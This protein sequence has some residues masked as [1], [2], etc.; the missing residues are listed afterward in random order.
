MKIL[1]VNNL[2][3]PYQR[4][5]AEEV[6][7]IMKTEFESAGHSVAIIS[8]AP[9]GRRDFQKESRMQNVY[10]LPSLFFYLCF[11]PLPLRFLWHLGNF[12]PIH[13]LQIKKIISRFQPDLVVTHN[14]VGIGFW[15]PL[16]LRIKKIR[17][18]HYLHDIQLLHPSGLL[19]YRQERKI[20]SFFSRCYQWL[21]RRFFGSPHKVISPSDWLINLHRQ[22][23]FFP[24]SERIVLP[25]NLNLSFRIRQRFSPAEAFHFIYIG[26]LEKHKGIIELLE[27]FKKLASLP[28][29]S[30]PVFLHLVGR[31]TY[32]EKIKSHPQIITYGFLPSHKVV[33]LLGRADCLIVPSLCYENYPTIIQKALAVGCPVIA[34]SLGGNIELL[35]KAHYKVGLYFPPTS[36]E[37][38]K[39]MH[40]AIK[41]I[42]LFPVNSI[43]STKRQFITLLDQEI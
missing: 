20:N 43:Q 3:F 42:A 36:Q 10:Y 21:T 25:P 12:L 26:Q 35:T 40:W 39:K 29:L 33:E 13:W 2:Y 5:G 24:Q 11:I 18:W 14:L 31:G 34:S 37:L 41:N 9:L 32:S 19:F 1:L 8:L 38:F 15:L 22:K 7:K 16:W 28:S 4:G 30:R 17:H 23:K 27:A 6:N